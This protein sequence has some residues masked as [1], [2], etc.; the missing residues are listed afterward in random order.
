MNE[1]STETTPAVDPDILATL[2]GQN[3]SLMAAFGDHRL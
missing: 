1:L 3:M 2:H